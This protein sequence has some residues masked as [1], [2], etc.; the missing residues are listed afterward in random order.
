MAG[1][2]VYWEEES[3]GP[4]DSAGSIGSKIMRVAVAGGTPTTLVNGRLNGF[5]P[6]PGPGFLPASWFPRGG[7][8]ADTDFVYFSDADFFQSY[9]VMAVPVSG[10]AIKILLADTTHVGSD[11]VRGMTHDAT[12]LYWVDENDVRALP[13]SGGPV[14]D[15]A[16][17]RPLA[18]GSVTRVGTNLYWIEARCCAH[19]DWGDVYTIP[20]TG[21]TPVLV[22]DSLVSPMSLASDA[23]HLFWIEGGVLGGI[24]GFTGLRASALDGSNVVNV[25]E[26]AEAGPFSAD[27]NAVYFANRLTLKSVSTAGGTPRRLA[28]GDFYI[29]DVVSDGE[30]VYWVEDGPAVVRSVSVNGGPVTTL[31][32][33]P[34]P[35]SRIRIDATYVYWLAHNDEIHRVPK[36]GGTSVRLVGPITGGATDFDIDATS[37]Y[38]SGWDSGVIMKAPLAGGS[39]TPLASLGPDQTRRIAAH[40]GKVYWIDQQYVASVT[41]DGQTTVPI[42]DGILSDPFSANGLAFDNQS[43][44]WTE[45]AMDAIRKATP[46]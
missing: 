6:P 9:R 45:I 2:Y 43:L 20:T 33:A 27:A 14:T 7:I 11:L 31:G 21:G 12:T 10:G 29:K 28:I 4:V 15:L 41:A 30:R 1:G 44:F 19:R 34:G 18:T 25:V 13:K 38:I 32:A 36:A 24:E 17:A 35:A 39:T 26:A 3:P 40:G 22:H 5:I 37:I 23:T 8:V 16:A 42:H 46:K